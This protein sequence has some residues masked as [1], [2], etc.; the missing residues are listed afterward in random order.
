MKEKFTIVTALIGLSVLFSSAVN[1]IYATTEAKLCP[2]ASY[3]DLDND[4]YVTTIDR[5][6]MV[7]YLVGD[8]T[9]TAEQLLR[10]DLDVN[11]QSGDAVDINLINQY[12]V[13]L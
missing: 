13:G 7:S 10:S 1:V 2:C 5:D 4:G 8:I 11:G 12:V 3:G 9:F 6:M